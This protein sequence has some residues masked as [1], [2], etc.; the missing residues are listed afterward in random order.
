MA[1]Q[2]GLLNPLGLNGIVQHDA[3]IHS[4]RESTLCETNPLTIHVHPVG[5]MQCTDEMILIDDYF[6]EAAQLRRAN[7][8]S[9]VFGLSRG[10]TVKP[11]FW[12][13]SC[14]HR[15]PRKCT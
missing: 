2:V 8:L 12:D 7:L 4:V 11:N 5:E 10:K 1:K 15:A 13:C 14:V 3:L 6:I 9:P